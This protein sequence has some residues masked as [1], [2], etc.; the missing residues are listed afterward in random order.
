MEDAAREKKMTLHPENH[1][2]LWLEDLI[3]T[4]GLKTGAELG[5]QEGVT[6]KHLIEN[7]DLTLLI[8]VDTWHN[9]R[10]QEIY[11]KFYKNLRQWEKEQN[12]PEKIQLWK[13]TTNEA[14]KKVD[15]DSLDFIFI[16]A[17]HKTAGVTADIQNWLPKVKAGGWITGHD[18]TNSQVQPVVKKLLGH[19][20]PIELGPDMVWGVKK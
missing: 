11:S 20:G 17:D 7:C 3:N 15:D 6:Y 14:S 13:M 4:H 18:W 9:T 16:D 19:L 5:V 8:G 12:E 2:K 1:R 10:H